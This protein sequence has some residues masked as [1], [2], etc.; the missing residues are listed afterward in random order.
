L[1][2]IIVGIVNAETVKM[3]RK[4]YWNNDAVPVSGGYPVL[5]IRDALRVNDGDFIKTR[6]Y[7]MDNRMW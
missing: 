3:F 2:N 5:A 6:D 7:L 1:N 4:W